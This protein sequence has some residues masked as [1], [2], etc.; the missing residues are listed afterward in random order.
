MRVMISHSSYSAVTEHHGPATTAAGE[1]GP[2]PAAGPPRPGI[3]SQSGF[4][5]SPDLT[6]AHCII[7]HLKYLHIKARP[8]RRKRRRQGGRTASADSMT[9]HDSE[10]RIDHCLQ[11][12]GDCSRRAHVPVTVQYHVKLM[13]SNV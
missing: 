3:P 2:T 4:R 5:V 10:R 11:C 6:E 7:K 13:Y 12:H 1:R 8:G 9:D